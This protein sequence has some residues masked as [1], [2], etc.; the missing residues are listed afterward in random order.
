MIRIVVTEMPEHSK[1][2]P[3]SEHI[4]IPECYECKLKK[5]INN[6]CDLE[7][8]KEC[9]HL[10]APFTFNPPKTEEKKLKEFNKLKCDEL[11]YSICADGR[12]C[13]DFCDME[14]PYGCKGE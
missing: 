3:F 9:E 2:C 4:Y 8:C 10:V 12:N 14:C 6:T 11:Y 1:D 13:T 7:H 5:G